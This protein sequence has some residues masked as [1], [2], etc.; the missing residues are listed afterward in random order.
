MRVLL[1]GLGW[2]WAGAVGAADLPHVNFENHPVH[3]LDR[4]PDGRWLAAAHTADNRVQLFAV[5][6]EGV[7]PMGHVVVGY[8]PVSVRFR[9]DGELW[10]VNHISDTVS[11]VDVATRSVKATLQT[12]DEPFDVVFARGRAFVSC[13]QAN[14]IL[15][16]DTSD[17]SRAPTV[18]PIRAEDP[19]ALAVSPDGSKVYAAIFES[20]NGSTV[21]AGGFAAINPGIANV[22]NDARGPYGGQN[23]PPNAG[24]RFDPPIRAGATPPRVSLIV[25][26]DAAGRWRDDNTGDWTDFVSG[27]LAQS[28]GRRPGWTLI[29]RD[30]AVIDAATLEVRYLERMMNIGMA[31]SV[32]PGTGRVALVGTD[33]RNQVRFE[34][35]LNGRFLE[36]KLALADPAGSAPAIVD[37]NPQINYVSSTLPPGERPKAIGDPRA[38]AWR[39]DGSRAFVAGMGSNNVLEID[40]SGTRAGEPI[41]VGE[42]PA[43]LVVDDARQRLYVWNHFEASLS[44]VDLVTRTETSRLAAFDPLPAAIR[45]GRP[46]LY[47]THRTSGTG[48]V[49]CA[50]CHVDARMD[51]LAWDLGDPSLPVKRFNQNCQTTIGLQPCQDWHEMKGPMTTQTLQDIIGHEP[52]HWRGDREGI[53]AF[54][55]AFEGL[56]GDDALLTPAEMQAFED[57]LAT[58]TFP[59]NPFRNFDNSLPTALPLEGHYTSG[60]FSMAGLPLG[61][62]NAVRGLE[63]YVFGLL[64]PPFQCASCHT[65]PTGMAVNGPLLLGALNFA[66]GGQVKP[67]GTMGENSLGIV[68]TDGGTNISIKTPQLRNM[69]DKVGFETTQSESLAGF[70]H[71]HDGAVDSLSRFL[72][73]N[74]FAVRSDQDVADLVALMLAFSGSEFPLQNPPLGAPAPLSKDA[75]AAVGGQATHAGGAVPERALAMLALARGGKIDLVARS[76]TQGW[77]F[78][79][80]SDR[81]LPADGGTPVEPTAMPAL[82][83]AS[84]PI[85]Y[86]AVPR[87]LGRRLGIDRDGDSVADGIERRQGS[88]P[89]D[90]GSTVARPLAGLWYNPARSGSGFDLQHAGSTMSLIWYTYAE[91]GSPTWYLAAGPRTNPWTATLERYTWNGTAAVG[92]PAGQVTL[93]FTDATNA[94]F[95]WTLGTRTGSESVTSLLAGTPLAAP[96]RTATWFDPADPGWGL[97]LFTSD[98]LRVAVAYFYDGAGQPRWVL[99]SGSNARSENL[100]MDSYRGACPHCA[101]VAP[102]TAG[103]GNLQ[104]AFD[105]ML[106]GRATVDVHDA[107][108][109]GSPWRRGP[110]TIAPLTEVASRAERR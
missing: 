3:A 18:V 1:A 108:S 84:R 101:Y 50:S 32:Q 23:P 65:L 22:V 40:G 38:I 72:S 79:A 15:V 56:L 63:R 96:E 44:T 13:S 76:S 20:G 81:F 69:Y 75:H 2:L 60:R 97:S 98:P 5:R 33:A 58:I 66:V 87:G 67:M 89:A 104:F 100:A 78:D 49:S 90:A 8:D 53:E 48:H 68:S 31:I 64:D 39:P 106:S 73:A 74:V 70:G 107:A 52:H 54:N 42:G 57:F 61:T 103:G 29:D 99:G 14:R 82:A 30:I 91:D 46:F 110:T 51:R 17:L 19:R 71:F 88:D 102:T 16:F 55:P 7:V 27:P 21:L 105:A 109:P 9:N 4:S 47:D 36:V 24:T 6:D 37:L 83:S 92:A 26:R 10:V 41:A 12:A 28:S 94:S 85:T 95:A 77:A 62:G 34:P 35:K 43:G 93:S 11:V 59:P 86:T 80:A 45:A 25:K